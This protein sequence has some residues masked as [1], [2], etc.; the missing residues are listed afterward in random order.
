MAGSGLMFAATTATTRPRAARRGKGSA[1]QLTGRIT[2]SPVTLSG[3]GPTLLI[4]P[5]VRAGATLTRL[6]RP[7]FLLNAHVAYAYP[8]FS[9]LCRTVSAFACRAT[10]GRVKLDS[11]DQTRRLPHHDPSR[12]CRRATVHSP[13]SRFYGAV[14]ACC[15]GARP[16]GSFLIDGEAIVTDAKGLAVFEFIRRARNRGAAVLCAFDLIELDG[17]D[18]RRAPIEHRKQ[19]LARLRSRPAS[20][21]RGQRALRRRRRNRVQVRLQARLRRHRVTAARLALSLR[22]FGAL[23]EGQEPESAGSEARSGRGLGR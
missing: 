6:F 2:S 7:Q 16:A 8:W 13:R 3:P 9:R 10:A 17:A 21:H 19:K 5:R 23:G 11:R 22:A 1:L 4:P 15:R 14:S 20:G 18:L 12:W